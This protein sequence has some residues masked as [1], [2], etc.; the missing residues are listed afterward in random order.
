M[1]AGI[2]ALNAE[3]STSGLIHAALPQVPG[4][5][6]SF[7]AIYLGFLRIIWDVAGTETGLA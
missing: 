2:K 7:V 6:V 1:A 3:G 4:K 5:T